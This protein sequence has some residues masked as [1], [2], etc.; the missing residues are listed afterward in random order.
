MDTDPNQT[1]PAASAAIS[2][3]ED[4][5]RDIVRYALVGNP[6]TGK[7]TLFNRLCG[8]RSKTANFPGSTVEAHIG[9]ATAPQV[10]YEIVDLP[11]HYGLNLDRPESQF[12]KDYL[13]GRVSQAPRPQA[14]LVVADA[15]NLSRNLIFVSQ[16]LQQGLPAVVALNM[17]DLAQRAGLTI[18]VRALSAYL[19]CPVVPICARSGAGIDR[20][21]EVMQ[22]PHLSDV[23]LPD[24]TSAQAAA[25]WADGVSA[26]SVGGASALGAASDTLT[27]RL[28]LAFTHPVLGIVAFA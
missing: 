28:D 7:T 20:L 25:D 8:I 5:G 10:R 22:A 13:A 19:G 2:S 11:G 3:V 21:L 27:G 6:N 17:I 4:P 23:A 18:D 15:T 1:S 9:V 26:Q 16:A 24:A 12:C 14:V